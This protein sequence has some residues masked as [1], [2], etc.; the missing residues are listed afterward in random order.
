MGKVSH[1]LVLAM[2][3]LTNLIG[4]KQ[5]A[6]HPSRCV[7]VYQHQQDA[8]KEIASVFLSVLA[9]CQLLCGAKQW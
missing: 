3:L 2:M 1:V 6:T 9:I 7:L 8:E 4:M 5:Y